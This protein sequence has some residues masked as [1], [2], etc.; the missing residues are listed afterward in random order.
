LACAE[1]KNLDVCGAILVNPM[2]A[3]LALANAEVAAAY[4]TLGPTI[5]PALVGRGEGD[6]AGGLIDGFLKRGPELTVETRLSVLGVNHNHLPMLAEDAMK[7]QRLLINNS[8]EM[9]IEAAQAI[10]EK[11]LYRRGGGGPLLDYSK[12]A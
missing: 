7:Q 6:R 1:P 9:T 8:P 12:G 2:L 10:H 5:F 11:A 3:G 4:G